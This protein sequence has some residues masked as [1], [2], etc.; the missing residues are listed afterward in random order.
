MYTSIRKYQ[1][2]QDQMAEVMLRVDR[3]FASRLEES[4]G[5]AGYYAI[6]CGNRILITVTFGDDRDAVDR[7]VG[8]AAEFVRDQLSDI[9]IERVEAATG[10]VGVSRGT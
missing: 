9:E 6:D 1:V 8:M 10:E 4:A 2:N 3:D 7:S 5:F